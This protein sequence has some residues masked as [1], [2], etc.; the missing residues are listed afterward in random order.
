MLPACASSS[1][2]WLHSPRDSTNI[3]NAQRTLA[4][5]HASLGKQEFVAHHDRHGGKDG[6]RNA[7]VFRLVGPLQAADHG[8][9]GSDATNPRGWPRGKR[10]A[11]PGLKEPA[12]FGTQHWVALPT[13]ATG[14]ASCVMAKVRTSPSAPHA[15]L[16][17]G[18]DGDCDHS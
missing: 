6:Q 12:R 13:C 15:E 2:Y 5:S 16:G 1:A 17:C 11:A 3:R 14:A 8:Q 10:F 4:C 7:A 18:G 9:H